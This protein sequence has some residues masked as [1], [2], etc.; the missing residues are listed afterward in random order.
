VR[1]RSGFGAWFRYSISGPC[2][3]GVECPAIS[4]YLE[5]D[6]PSIEVDFDNYSLHTFAPLYP[7]IFYILSSA[8]NATKSWPREYNPPESMSE[9]KVGDNFP[10]G[11]TFSY[12]PYTPEN[13]DITSCG[14]PINYD[15]S[16]GSDSL[17][18]QICQVCGSSIDI[19]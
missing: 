13:G 18:S 19:H 7:A 14:I 15:A 10:E 12:V 9:L 8:S 11:V 2:Q 6:V 5:L 3:G 4:V 1:D 17:F 16:K